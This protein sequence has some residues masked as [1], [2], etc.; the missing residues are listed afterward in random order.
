MSEKI[1]GVIDKIDNLLNDNK[2][3]TTRVGLRFMTSVLK[4]ALIAIAEVADNNAKVDLR[5][6]ELDTSL[7]EFLKKQQSNDDKADEERRRWRWAIITPTIG[8]LVVE[9]ARWLLGR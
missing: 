7:T 8:L 1:S 4:D 9:I 3:F 2:N 6:K 5:L